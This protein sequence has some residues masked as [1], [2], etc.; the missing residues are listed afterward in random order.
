MFKKIIFFP[1]GN[2]V[3]YVYAHNSHGLMGFPNPNYTSDLLVKCN[4]ILY[5][6][7]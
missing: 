4:E 7:Q 3:A 5:M 2:I 1:F 6:V